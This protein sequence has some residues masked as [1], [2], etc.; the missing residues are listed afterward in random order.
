MLIA[1][2]QTHEASLAFQFVIG[3]GSTPLETNPKVKFFLFS[4]YFLFI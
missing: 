1:A 4:I 3:G 2:T